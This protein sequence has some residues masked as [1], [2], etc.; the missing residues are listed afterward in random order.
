MAALTRTAGF[1]G[2]QATSSV[3]FPITPDIRTVTGDRPAVDLSGL[4]PPLH[5][6]MFL[7]EALGGQR[8]LRTG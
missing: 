8:P 2:K 3:A 1:G 6:Q 7:L 4:E 5:G